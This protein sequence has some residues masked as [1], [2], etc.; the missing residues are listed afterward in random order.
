MHQNLAVILRNSKIVL[1]YRPRSP[2]PFEG[3]RVVVLGAAAS[4][5]DISLEICLK[6]KTVFLSHNGPKIPSTLP[7][8]LVQVREMAFEICSILNLS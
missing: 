4:G 6:A 2:E 1:L 7:E 3:L 8:N 5:V